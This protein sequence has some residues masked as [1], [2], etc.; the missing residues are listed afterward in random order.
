MARL[1][2]VT[3]RWFLRGVAGSLS[4]AATSYPAKGRARPATNKITVG[5]IGVGDRGVWL[6]CEVARHG[7]N[8]V[9]LC[10]VR[11]VRLDRARRRCGRRCCDVAITSDYRRVLDRNDIDA[12][13]IATPGYCHH[14]MVMDAASAGRHVYLEPPIGLTFDEGVAVLRA[15]RLRRCA[16]QV[17]YRHR[18]CPR[19]RRTRE[20]VHSGQIGQ[21]SWVQL[22][23][24]YDASSRQGSVRP[25]SHCLDIARWIMNDPR[26][27]SVVA[28][29]RHDASQ[30]ILDHLHAVYDYGGV[31]CVFDAFSNNSRRGD[32]I[33][34]YGTEGAL[35][36][37]YAFAL[38]K[39][40]GRN[41]TPISNWQ[42]DDR[43]SAHMRNWLTCIATGQTPNAPLHLAQDTLIDL[44]LGDVAH[45]TGR[46]V[47][48]DPVRRTARDADTS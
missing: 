39:G 21:L 7:A 11:S 48:W 15:A 43:G 30:E 19:W 18:T 25:S 29:A 35:A 42:A 36:Y 46:R 9:A 14:D 44:H 8:L 5:V 6:A 28:S 16:I 3:R 38:F 4:C 27:R 40:I 33:T 23:A 47:M 12:V 22:V 24:S 45:R 26:C 37:D 2:K 31:A 10:D 1:D 20:V 32:R 13:V 41:A 34:F 17:G